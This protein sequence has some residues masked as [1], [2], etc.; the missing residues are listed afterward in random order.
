MST[1]A[2]LRRGKYSGLRIE[3]I[4]SSS[5]KWKASILQTG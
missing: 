5:V 1:G 3:Y 4:I 2:F